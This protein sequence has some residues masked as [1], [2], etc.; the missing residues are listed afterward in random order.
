[1]STEIAVLERELHD[2]GLSRVERKRRDAR[3]RIIRAAETRLLGNALWSRIACAPFLRAPIL[4]CADGACICTFVH[5][6]AAHTNGTVLGQFLCRS[7][8]I[9]THVLATFA[10]LRTRTKV[11][12]WRECRPSILL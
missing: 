9:L 10:V 3:L 11:I 4:L 5:S 2:E 8:S 12:S 1:M 7:A 6:L